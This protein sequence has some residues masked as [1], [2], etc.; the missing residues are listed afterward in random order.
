MRKPFDV[1]AEGLASEY[2]WG[3]KTRLEHFCSALS[4]LQTSDPAAFSGLKAQIGQNRK[5]LK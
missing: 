5:Q 4:D 1:L 2:S 3:D